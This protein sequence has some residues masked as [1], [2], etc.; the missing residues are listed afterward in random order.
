MSPHLSYRAEK[1][2]R[3]TVTLGSFSPQ[4]FHICLRSPNR[5]KLSDMSPEVRLTFFHEFGHLL[6]Y[7]TSYIGLKD[8][9]YWA[10][11]ID[12]LKNP[13]Q[14]LTPEEKVTW[15][16]ERILGLA[17][18]KQTLSIDDEYYFEPYLEEFQNAKDNYDKWT[19]VAVT[20]RLFQ[21]D[22][23]L[24][25]D[26]LFW[27]TRFYI[28]EPDLGRSFLRIPIGMRTILEHMAKSIDFIGECCLRE[29]A[30]VVVAFQKEA[31]LPE[32]LHYYCLAYWVGSTM[33]RKYG[34]SETWRAFYVCG[35]IVL[36]LSEIPFD[37]PD[38]W[39]S[40]V[41][42]AEKH[43]PDLAPRMKHPHPSFIFPLL[44]RA[45]EHS[46][47]EFDSNDLNN[48]EHNL[49]LLLKELNIPPLSEL[50]THTKDLS[51]QVC[52][53]LDRSTLGKSV[54]DLVMWGTAYAES[55]GWANKLLGPAHDLADYSPVP[56]IFEDSTHTD[57][58]IL[59]MDVVFDLGDCVSRQQE[60][61]RFPFT[62][63]VVEE[64]K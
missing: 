6:H 38:I 63:N 32:M 34:I 61:L 26:Y 49:E 46:N 33:T 21:T 4:T 24:S 11:T 30:D 27:A 56:I 31:R 44:L 8:L 29:P 53:T 39:Q 42:Y 54:K 36:L 17:R 20:G 22:G 57:G 1:L 40:L 25:D 37:A 48:M 50:Q 16:S 47:A 64:D 19:K 23:R 62:R 12:V 43:Q 55:L 51:V 35:Q 3:E 58:T 14:D 9:R 5:P 59:S 60:M 13:P 10:E 41:K 45:V 52:D 18:N 15:Q 28:G 2:L 7:L